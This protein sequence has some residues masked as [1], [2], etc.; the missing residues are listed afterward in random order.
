MTQYLNPGPMNFMM[1]GNKL[2]DEEWEIAV[3]KRCD[4]CHELRDEGHVCRLED[5]SGR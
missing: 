4:K 1:K 5:E 3:G 2:S